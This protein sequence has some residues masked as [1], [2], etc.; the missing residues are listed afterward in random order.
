MEIFIEE[1]SSK[2]ILMAKLRSSLKLSPMLAKLRQ[3]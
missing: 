1:N 3:D 2:A